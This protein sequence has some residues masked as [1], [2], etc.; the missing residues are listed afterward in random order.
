MFYTTFSRKKNNQL[1]EPM[2]LGQSVNIIRYDQQKYIVFENLIQK[3]LSFFWRP[4]EID[5]SKDRID[6]KYLSDYEKHIFIS[7][8]KYQTLLDSIQGRSPSLV[9]LPI[10][11]IPEL[12][13]W[14]QTWSFFE[15]IHSRSYTHIIR[16]IFYN[17]SI[18]FDDIVDHYYIVKRTK[19][20]S[21]YYDDLIILINNLNINKDLILNKKFLN[22]I[23]KKL[24]LCLI[25]VNALESIRFYISFVCSF[26]FAERSLME[27][28]AKIIRFIARDESLH[29]LGT[30]K[31]IN[32]MNFIENEN[33]FDIVKECR[34]ESYYLY[35]KV[36]E[37][38]KD[39]VKYLFSDGP[40]LGLSK[41]ILWNYIEYITNIR[42]NSIFLKMPFKIRKNPLPWLD[43]WLISENVQ[44]A[45]QETEISSY[46]VGQ[47]DSDIDVDVLSDINI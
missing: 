38:E 36:S 39:W 19:D 11:S 37:Q 43:N 15:T 18:I 24:Y 46:L 34:E 26:S 5:L 3:Q 20:I 41:E 42:M 47:V 4:E 1:K 44:I 22:E 14:I 17:P 32:I 21:K 31:I 2:F 6:F 12:E 45:P 13:T 35:V 28:N 40:I 10:V 8:L 23:K 16:N 7:N 27:G 33:M 9:F 30:Q 29:L 25:S